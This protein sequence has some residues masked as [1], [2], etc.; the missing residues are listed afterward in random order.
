MI[1]TVIQ[2]KWLKQTVTLMEI[3][4]AKR[5]FAFFSPHLSETEVNKTT[6]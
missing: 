2:F 1:H 4:T 5:S 6:A 3:S